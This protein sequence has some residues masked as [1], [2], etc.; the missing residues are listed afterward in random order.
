MVYMPAAH[1]E[2]DVKC[3]SGLSDNN[4]DLLEII[5]ESISFKEFPN[6]Y[7]IIGTGFYS[8]VVILDENDKY[9][10]KLIYKPFFDYKNLKYL[11]NEIQI[12]KIVNSPYIV[13][14]IDYFQ[15]K[16]LY[17]LKLERAKGDLF[18]FSKKN[19]ISIENIKNCIKD[20]C[21]SLDYIHSKNIYHRDIKSENV[22]IFIN[23]MST[24]SFKLCDFGLG[25]IGND[26]D[27]GNCGT[28]GFF[29][30]EVSN[31]NLYSR[32]KADYWS[33]GCI[34]LEQ[35]IGIDLFFSKWIVKCYETTN[36]LLANKCEKELK[37]FYNSYYDPFKIEWVSVKCLLHC[38]PSCRFLPYPNNMSNLSCEVS[39]TNLI[40]QFLKSNSKKYNKI[41]PI[42]D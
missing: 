7:K 40:K 26:L 3:E 14:M 37:Q 1:E 30:P 28:R 29:A 42:E 34:I 12:L 16:N 13:S 33:F 24:Y 18:E 5:N 2:G 25:V 9:V 21:Q 38:Y 19:L 36:D 22:L 32:K 17:G 27:K 11:I 8:K 41:H 35:L 23:D 10:F 6:N 31:I 15:S 39:Q 4:S 20:L